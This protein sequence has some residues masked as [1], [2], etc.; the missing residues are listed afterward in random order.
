MGFDVSVIADIFKFPWP[1][2][3]RYKHPYSISGRYEITAEM[4]DFEFA[5]SLPTDDMFELQ[6]IVFSATG[7]KDSDYFSIMLNDDY[8]MKNIY[9]KELGQVKEVRPVVKIDPSIDTLKF[10]YSNST[11]TSKV[12]WLDFDMVHRGP[13]NSATFANPGQNCSEVGT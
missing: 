5:V 2:F 4:K 12:V 6:S 9:T 3:P 11:G 13:L 10:I 7:Y 1:L 8:I